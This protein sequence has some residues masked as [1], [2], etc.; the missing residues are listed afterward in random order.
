MNWGQV[1]SRWEQLVKSARENWSKLSDI[2]LQQIS[3]KREQ[4][5]RRNRRPALCRLLA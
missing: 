3:G 4:H 1:E 2:D 5:V